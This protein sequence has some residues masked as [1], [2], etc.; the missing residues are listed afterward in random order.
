MIQIL[1]SKEEIQ[2]FFADISRKTNQ[3]SISLQLF[4]DKICTEIKDFQRFRGI[5]IEKDLEKDFGFQYKSH[6]VKN[7][8]EER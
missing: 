8:K 5:H 1:G 3:A 7:S 2:D 4:C 6:I